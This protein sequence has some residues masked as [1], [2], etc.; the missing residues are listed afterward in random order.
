[1]VSGHGFPQRVFVLGWAG[2]REDY[3]QL[4]MRAFA[5]LSR[6]S[7]KLSSYHIRCDASL[8]PVRV[9]HNG[10]C[11]AVNGYVPALGTQTMWARS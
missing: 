10:T 1:M 2:Q 4:S 7:M 9:V 8:K 6:I 11:V 5:A 3:V